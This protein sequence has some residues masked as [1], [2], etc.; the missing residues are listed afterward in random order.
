MITGNNEIDKLLSD[1]FMGAK[2]QNERDEVVKNAEALKKFYG[3]AQTTLVEPSIEDSRATRGLDLEFKELGDDLTLRNEAIREGRARKDIE[4][5]QGVR[6]DA[7]DRDRAGVVGAQ[8][9]IMKPEYAELAAGREMSDAAYADLRNQEY[10][11]RAAFRDVQK[12]ALENQKFGN[13][14]NL[15]KGLGIGGAILLS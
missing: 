1:A 11:D 9:A 2:D 6:S 15:V 4:F 5:R 14:L 12:Q 13:I 7:R 3:Q 10:A 8:M